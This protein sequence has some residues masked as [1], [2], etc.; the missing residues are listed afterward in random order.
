M[1]LEV[2]GGA[3]RGGAAFLVRSTLL[4][5]PLAV[6]ISASIVGLNSTEI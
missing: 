1:R 2:S 6:A 3:V 4:A 5:S